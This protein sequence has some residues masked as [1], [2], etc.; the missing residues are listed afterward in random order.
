[1]A[2]I[3]SGD[4][5]SPEEWQ[6]YA[7]EAQRQRGELLRQMFQMVG[8]MTAGPACKDQRGELPEQPIQAAAVMQRNADGRK[9]SGSRP[10]GPDG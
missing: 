5:R 7:E 8:P 4:V 3:D 9:E 2:V 10:S 1:M 6:E